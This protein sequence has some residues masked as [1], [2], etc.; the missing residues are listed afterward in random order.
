MVEELSEF[1]GELTEQNR[2]KADRDIPPLLSRTLRA[3]QAL[4]RAMASLKAN[5]ADQAIDQQEQAADLLAEAYAIVTAQNERL[6]LLQSLLMFQ[7]SV[8]FANRYMTDI[9]AQQRDLIAETR[10]LDSK[11]ASQL[12]PLL[13][14]LRRCITD[15]APLLDAVAARVD[16]GSPLAF[17]GTD[18]EDAVASLEAGDHLDALDAQDVVAESLAEVNTLVQA[19]KSETGYV[20]E[21]V[22]FLHG[23]V[24]RISTLEYEQDE[25]RQQM[26]SAS[27]GELKT[28]AEQQ[29]EILTRA[30]K[31]GQILEAVT[32]MAEYVEAGA[33]MRKALVALE[34]GETSVVTEQM[35]IA[36]LTLQKNAES[37]FT[38]IS[39]L[40]G[41]PNIEIMSFTD[42]DIKRLIDVL[43][44]ASAH[45][46][47]FRNTNIADAQ[48]MGALAE[49]QVALATRCQELSKVGDS[50]AMLNT[51]SKQ[52][53]AA[54]SAMGASDRD[55][56]K[57]QQQAALQTLRHFIIEQ[58]L[59]LETAV[60]PAA[61]QDGDPDADGEGS[62][63]ESAF[64]AGFISD[65]VSGEAPKDSRTEWKVRGNRNRA[66][67]NQNFARELP[68]E[69]RG[70]LKDYY[71]RVAE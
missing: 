62:D 60:P 54:A 26:L 17:A 20:A 56:I 1:N 5:D 47:L 33:L 31:E 3:E 66:A 53:A 32:G 18:L 19:V 48:A 70:L 69:Y 37:L 51:A 65:F 25:L 34:S 12:L 2:L 55:A 63:S 22:E 68:L 13:G 7:R 49:Q 52:L 16:A 21:I 9:V 71:E 11:D 35:E 57:R 40:H 59:V 29:R 43:A 41:L 46:V 23:A 50:H 10:A 36:Q 42:P 38:V 58:A 28:L 4:R 14:H 67:L 64:S 24:A 45:K 15:V 39:M 8:G 27:Q 44:V 61:A 6:L 30:A